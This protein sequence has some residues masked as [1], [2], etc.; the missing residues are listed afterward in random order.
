M[1]LT[2]LTRWAYREWNSILRL[3]SPVR[4]RQDS[5]HPENKP[6]PWRKGKSRRNRTAAVLNFI[7]C[8]F[9]QFFESYNVTTISFPT[10]VSQRL[11]DR[12]RVTP[13]ANRE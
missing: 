5:Q 12:R 3:A 11:E 4:Q 6:S 8:L 10:R 1:H 2:F 7:G 9:F 13:S